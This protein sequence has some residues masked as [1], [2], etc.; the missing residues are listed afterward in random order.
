ME[1]SGSLSSTGARRSCPV[2]MKSEGGG[3]SPVRRH[4]RAGLALLVG[5]NNKR[6]KFQQKKMSKFRAFESSEITTVQQA[7]N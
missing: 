7:I 3:G 1:S 4:L 2:R 6:K 5:S